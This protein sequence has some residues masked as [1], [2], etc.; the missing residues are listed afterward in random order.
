M[1][2]TNIVVS[3][4]TVILFQHVAAVVAMRLLAY[5]PIEES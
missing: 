1:N 5:L 2:V 3:V 4:Y